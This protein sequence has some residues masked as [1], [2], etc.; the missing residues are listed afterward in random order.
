MSSLGIP[1]PLADLAASLQPA[2]PPIANAATP[3]D[4]AAPAPQPG[5]RVRSLLSN[6]FQGPRSA[7]MAHVG[8]PTHQEQ[9]QE[10]F[11]NQMLEKQFQSGE[12]LKQAQIGQIQAESQLVPLQLP[13]G[14]SVM[15]PAKHAATL[16]SRLAGAQT[17]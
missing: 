8:L 15:L 10:A 6:F 9:A 12:Q 3:Q 7:M 4:P 5:G 2:A 17:S 1:D 11:Q 16:A 14:T 13:D